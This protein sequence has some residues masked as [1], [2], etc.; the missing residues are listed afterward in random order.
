MLILR[1]LACAIFDAHVEIEDGIDGPATDT[2]SSPPLLNGGVA[3]SGKQT[4]I[5]IG[6]QKEGAK[7]TNGRWEDQMS[8]L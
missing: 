1:F 4:R 2:L 8:I 5:G 6:L 7:R 3:I